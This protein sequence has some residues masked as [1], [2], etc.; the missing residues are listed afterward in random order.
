MTLPSI[1]LASASPRRAELLRAAGINFTIRV[2]NVDETLLPD[3]SPQTYV[4]RLARL[5]AVAVAQ[6]N[7][8][9]IGA[10]TTVVI[11]NEVAGKPVDVADAK[12]MLCLLNNN[13]HEVLTGV[14]LAHNHDIR[15]EVALTRV[16][17]AMMS[18]EEI[19]WR[20]CNSRPSLTLYRAD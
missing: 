18:E 3:E 1:I 2:A 8:I 11:G 13:W 12:R 10:D 14:T 15:T 4:A 19:A 16:K 17:F 9:V 5:K 7:E 20:V 6:P